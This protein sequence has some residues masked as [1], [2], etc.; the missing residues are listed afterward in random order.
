MIKKQLIYFLIVL[1][2]LSFLF[3]LNCSESIT[4]PG[5]EPGRRDYIWTVDTLNISA[6]SYRI[7]GSSPTDVWSIN[8]SDNFNTIWHYDGN[9]WTTD[10][11]FRLIWPNAIWGFSNNNVYIGG[12]GGKIW[13]YDGNN[14]KENVVLVKDGHR[15]IVLDNMWGTSP[16]DLYAFGA[17][18]DEKG[19]YNKSVI[20]HF[21]NNN[22]IMLDTNGLNGIVEHLYK[23]KS[24]NK[25]YLQVI[26]IGGTEH[27]DSTLI[28]EDNDAKYNK[29]YSSPETQGL[30]ADISIIDGE[31]YFILG[32]EIAR[33][34]D[35]LFKTI[36]NID[37]PNFYHRIWGR[38]SK[39]I[40]LLMTDGLVHYNG[41]DMEYL[42][43][44]TYPDAKPATQIFSAA[45]FEKDVFFVT[46]EPPTGLKY[47]YHGKV[48]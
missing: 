22:W 27:R 23:N 48:N 44:F 37:N 14:W 46:Y 3:L 43:H 12:S 20:A 29:I 25:I 32:N 17:Y 38:N 39:D 19:Y 31:V 34:K 41:N 7:W 28:Y 16:D 13:K 4:E 8:Q 40:F 10:G 9:S 5:P 33:R 30:Q 1:F 36:L 26:K 35:N 18:P 11:D 2:S 21:V 15:N 24:D 45:I 42:F 47:I 6:P